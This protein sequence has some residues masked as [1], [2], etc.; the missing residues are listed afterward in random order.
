MYLKISLT[1]SSGGAFRIWGH[2][3]ET[4]YSN[5]NAEPRTNTLEFRGKRVDKEKLLMWKCNA[6]TQ[7]QQSSAY[8]QV[9]H[10]YDNTLGWLS[11]LTFSALKTDQQ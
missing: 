10:A 2:K 11:E 1:F 8:K 4:Q 6:H 3:V 5:Y 7:T 9:T